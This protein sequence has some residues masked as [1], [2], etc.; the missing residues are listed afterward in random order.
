MEL[1]GRSIRLVGWTPITVGPV[2]GR[3]GLRFLHM[4]QCAV[5]RS[6]NMH[7]DVSNVKYEDLLT[8]EP[9]LPRPEKK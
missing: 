6:A 1:K 7:T 2:V 3:S 4:R 5:D 9:M 8:A